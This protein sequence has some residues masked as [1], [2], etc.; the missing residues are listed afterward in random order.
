M[1]AELLIPS[2]W[3]YLDEAEKTK[4]N[5]FIYEYALV[6]FE[7]VMGSRKKVLV[8]WKAQ[9]SEEQIAEFCA[10]YAKR[11]KQ[12]VR[13]LREGSE[14]AILM[15]EYFVSDMSHATSHREN[16]I[17]MEVASAAWT[18]KLHVCKA[19]GGGCTYDGDMRCEF[20]DRMERGGYLS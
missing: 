14:K 11:M 6:L 2:S 13:A 4:L 8:K 3:F 17:I 19:C 20:F 12:S 16:R 1:K 10:Y 7:H 15:P 5:W 18:E 9:Q